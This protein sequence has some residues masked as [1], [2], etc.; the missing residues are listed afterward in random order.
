VLEESQNLGGVSES[1]DNLKALLD[2]S[3]SMN[4]SNNPSSNSN[5]EDENSDE[6]ETCYLDI[7]SDNGMLR[8]VCKQLRANSLKAIVSPNFS[9]VQSS[10]LYLES[11]IFNIHLASQQRF[12]NLTGGSIDDAMQM[13]VDVFCCIRKLYQELK[14]TFSMNLELYPN[15]PEIFDQLRLMEEEEAK[16]LEIEQNGGGEGKE[17]S[18]K[19]K[20]KKKKKKKVKSKLSMGNLRIYQALSNCEEDSFNLGQLL[21]ISTTISSMIIKMRKG[22]RDKK[23]KIPKGMRDMD[24][25]DLVIRNYIIGL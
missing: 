13:D 1:F 10:N 19:S 4:N 8:E 12:S 9:F 14:M 23:P 18:K 5:E 20:K 24:G 17:S 7:C 21:D 15:L 25:E 22:G 16:A 11:A 2:G 6:I 3:K